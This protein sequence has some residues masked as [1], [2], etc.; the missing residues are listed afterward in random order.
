[1]PHLH[2][3]T[4]TCYYGRRRIHSHLGTCEHCKRYTT[5]ESYD[6]TLFFVMLLIPIIPLGKKRILQQCSA[7]QRHRVLNRSKWEEAKARDGADV[8]EKLQNDPNDRDALLKAIAFAVSYQDEPLFD[9]L[10][11]R[12]GVEGTA[13][14]L[15]QAQLG[16][17][18]YYFAR[19][20]ETEKA[21]R[22]SLALQNSETVREGL[23][24][25]LLKQDRP[26]EARPY[27]QHILTNKKTDSLGS[28][29]YL[30]EGYQAQGRHEEALELLDQCEEAF[31]SAMKNKDYQKQ[32]KTSKRYLGTSK[33]IHSTVLSQGRSGY[34]EGNWTARVPYLIAL[35]VPVLL[36]SLYLGSAI[37]LGQSQ[38]V[39][40]VNGTS[41]PYAVVVEGKEYNLPPFGGLRV[42]VHEGDV[43][44]TFRDPKMGLEPVVTHIETNFWGRPF[45]G[46]TFIINPDES[47]VILEEEL[48]YGA[49]NPPPAGP[50][51]PH[52]GQSFYSLPSFDYEFETFP[53]YIDVSNNTE[54]LRKT[55]VALSQYST[56]EYRLGW[57]QELDKSEQ[58]KFCKRVLRI[59]P[60]NSVFLN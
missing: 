56:P 8:L 50:P 37:W 1:M 20:P 30:I 27:L 23:A 19:W 7:C 15:I 35:L 22:T 18:Y 32:R 44:V 3:G 45:G 43:E 24:W 39:Y 16:D 49:N 21:F 5:L 36:L 25:A 9:S 47:A 33:K 46:Q 48:F 60:N 42:R 59:E 52:F 58:L 11:E 12:L 10:V 14:A 51:T 54:Q 55:R 40:L 38:K 13:D 57:M 53:P 2:N 17:G 4:G 6:T 41:Q 34:R 26:E 29:Y 28:I 31:P